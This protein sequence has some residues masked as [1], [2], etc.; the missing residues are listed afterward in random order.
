MATK[1]T[2]ERF[3]LVGRPVPLLVPDVRVWVLVSLCAR[4]N[5]LMN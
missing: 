3:P 5:A 1:K 4:V 2:C